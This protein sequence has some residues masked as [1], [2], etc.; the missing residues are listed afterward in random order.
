MCINEHVSTL[1]KN[2]NFCLVFLFL[3]YFILI[4]FIL[5]YFKRFHTLF[6]FVQVGVTVVIWPWLKFTSQKI[7]SDS[8]LTLLQVKIKQPS[9]HLLSWP[10][11]YSQKY[12]DNIYTCL[13]IIKTI[14]NLLCCFKNYW[15]AY[16]HCVDYSNNVKLVMLL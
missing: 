4:N 9:V 7:L 1:N 2:C 5:F 15:W 16:N 14:L 13:L 10:L 8:N 12:K 6:D 3:F 11:Y